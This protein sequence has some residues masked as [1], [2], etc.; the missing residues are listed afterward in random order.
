MTPHRLTCPHCSTAL[1]LPQHRTNAVVLCPR[2]QGRMP[3]P[4]SHAN[5][6]EVTATDSPALLASIDETDSSFLHTPPHLR[7]LLA[8]LC[9]SLVLAGGFTGLMAK[10]SGRWPA[11]HGFL[12]G[13]ALLLGVLALLL[14]AVIAVQ[15][16]WPTIEEAS[17]LNGLVSEFL[18]MPLFILVML[19]LMG[20]AFVLFIIGWAGGTMAGDMIM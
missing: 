17:G 13:F 8:L 5:N 16:V 6:G 7:R 3:N 15:L 18:V 20:A 1:R 4:A 11:L 2:C 12:G 14:I 9:S 19:L 10:A